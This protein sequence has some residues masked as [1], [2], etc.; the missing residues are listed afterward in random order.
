MNYR[1]DYSSKENSLIIVD[2]L[3]EPKILKGYITISDCCGTFP[4]GLPLSY[5]KLFVKIMESAYHIN[6][7]KVDCAYLR[8]D[9]KIIHQFYIFSIH[10]ALTGGKKSVVV[11][12]K[13]NNIT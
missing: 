7:G 9:R 5:A 3:D 6:N 10:C 8:S 13:L 1:I 2:P 12:I 11:N 4:D